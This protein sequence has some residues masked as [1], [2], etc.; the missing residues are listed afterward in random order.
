[1][2]AG[3]G[4]AYQVLFVHV[5]TCTT[6]TIAFAASDSRRLDFLQNITLIG[7]RGPV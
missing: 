3:G 2:E 5:S 1:V 7:L 6:C 4:A